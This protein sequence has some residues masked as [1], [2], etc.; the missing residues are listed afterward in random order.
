MVDNI[1]LFP[2][3]LHLPTLLVLKKEYFIHKFALKWG[4]V[5]SRTIFRHTIRTNIHTYKTDKEKGLITV[6]LR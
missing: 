5:Y 6:T 3:N 4:Y 1:N 2:L